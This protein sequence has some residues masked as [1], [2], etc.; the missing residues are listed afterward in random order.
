MLSNSMKVVSMYRV[1]FLSNCAVLLIIPAA[2]SISQTK[3]NTL[4]ITRIS[5]IK[6]QL[7]MNGRAPR[8]MSAKCF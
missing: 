5:R 1:S 4:L 2:E 6:T 3:A 8:K 7:K